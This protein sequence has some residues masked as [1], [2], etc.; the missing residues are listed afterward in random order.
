MSLRS[1]LKEAMV[2][3]L[4]RAGYVEHA[5]QVKAE[6]FKAAGDEMLGLAAQAALSVCD[7]YEEVEVQECNN[8]DYL[9]R[10]PSTHWDPRKPSFTV[11]RKKQKPEPDVTELARRA[12]KAWEKDDTAHRFHVA[13]SALA[14]AVEKRQK[15][16]ST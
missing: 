5:R 3:A 12:V 6:L 7:E 2:V 14:K 1:D 13:M 8:A 15:H 4:E 11:Y 16:G 10:R 9:L